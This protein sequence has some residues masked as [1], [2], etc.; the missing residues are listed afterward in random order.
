MSSDPE[1]D[2]M[3]AREYAELDAQ[4]GVS[5]YEYRC[6]YDNEHPTTMRKN[7]EGNY[8]RVCVEGDWQG[9]KVIEFVAE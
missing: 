3:K 4:V 2:A 8:T 1:Y 7:G 9:V 5:D 6:P